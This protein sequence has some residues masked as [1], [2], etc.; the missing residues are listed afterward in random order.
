MKSYTKKMISI[1]CIEDI[2][3]LRYVGKTKQKLKDR[4]N[5]HLCEKKL[6]RTNTSSNKLNLENSIIYEI[7]K[8]EEKDSKER[9]AYWIKE[10]NAVNILKLNVDRKEALRISALNY[11]KNNKEAVKYR[12]SWNNLINIDLDLFK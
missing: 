4:F 5:N 12:K 6:N 10:L 8:C 3:D 1:Y 9:E 7:E 11:W 2:N